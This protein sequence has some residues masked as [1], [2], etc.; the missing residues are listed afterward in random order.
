MIRRVNHPLVI[1]FCTNEITYNKKRD[2]NIIRIQGELFRATVYNKK[3]LFDK[4]LFLVAHFFFFF[5]NNKVKKTLELKKF[6]MKKL[7]RIVKL[8][9]ILC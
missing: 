1:Q 4:F 9:I 7:E 5:L 3:T 6:Q 2:N 8:L